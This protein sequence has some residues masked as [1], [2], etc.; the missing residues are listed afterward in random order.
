MKDYRDTVNLPVTDFSM[1]AELAQREPQRIKWWKENKIYEKNLQKRKNSGKVFILHDGPPYSNG[2]I[3]L[4]TALNK[5]LK[6]ILVKYKS[7]KGF[8]APYIPGWDNH[9]MPIELEVIK[10]H[11]DYK[12]LLHDASKIK[13]SDVKKNLRNECREFAKKWVS[14]QREEFERLG[15]LGEWDATYLTM[16]PDYEAKELRV[17]A[18]LV[19]RGYIYRGYLPVHWCPRCRTTLAM[20]EIEYKDK[21][22]PSLWF[23]FEPVDSEFYALVWTTTPWTIISN[24][25][26]AVHPD[27][28]YV[29][30][31][32]GENKYLLAKDRLEANRDILGD[33]YKIEK[34][35]KGKE[36]EGLRFKHPFFDRISVMINGTFVTTEDGTGIVHIAP[37]HGKEDFEVG[38]EYQLP[39]LSPVDEN[40]RFTNEVPLFEGLDTTEASQKVIEVLKS[41]GKFV[42]LSKIIH[43]YPH[44]WRCKGPL[45]FRATHQ[46]FL[47]VDHNGLRGKAL[48]EIS[49]VRWHPE[50]GESRIYASVKERPDWVI[51]RQRTW[52]VFIPSARCKQC[53]ESILLPEVI[54]S[55]AY[56]V[57]RGEQDAW[58]ER[59]IE[60]FLPAG[61]KCPHC[62]GSEFEKE[63][64][65]LDVW[66]DSGISYIVVSEKHGLPWPCDVYLEGSDQHR[67]WFNASLMLGTAYKGSAPYKAVITHGWVVDEEGKA[68]HK[69]LGNV[70]LPEEVISKYGADILRL[71][72]ASSDYTD[73]IRLGSEIL[74]RLV[75]SYR[76]IR[77]TIRFMLGN[78]YDW[79]ETKRVDYRE[80]FPLE[81]Y[82]LGRW[83]EVKATVEDAY[84]NYYFYKVYHTLFNFMVVDLSAFYLD[85][86]KDRLYTWGRESLGRRS[87]Q[88]AIYDILRELLVILHPIIPFTTEEAWQY[89][90]GEKEE[91]VFLAEWPARSELWDNEV[92]RRDFEYLM[93]IREKVL[94]LIERARKD[95]KM[96]SDRLEA[97]V[98]IL[99]AEDNFK[100]VLETYRPFLEELFIVSQVSF[101]NEDS[102]GVYEEFDGFS[103]KIVH[104][105]GN[106][107]ERC[108][109]WH[110]DVG[111]DQEHP[112]LCPKCLNVVKGASK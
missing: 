9:G 75:D 34:V 70:I 24:V 55:L 83:N 43:S 109:I 69:S 62:G 94:L 33:N 32:T 107:C 85:V 80:M 63:D 1:K 35:L 88:T 110:E 64:N 44:C 99:Y 65:I 30:V 8:F 96:L 108:W 15:V 50:E 12:E 49:S 66:F 36:L 6:D 101:E 52:G 46:W 98:L 54:E 42:K 26:L 22:S 61:F 111:K 72:V 13:S 7:L 81:K 20:A 25:A 41:N 47:R 105:R 60:D 39:V 106:K 14:I 84:E 104:A 27:L 40:G 31:N 79:D 100:R 51:S 77:N 18:E 59:E 3:H 38:R 23:K 2:H 19:R 37:G 68:M 53:G 21:E 71:W 67:G 112:G 91:S 89:L 45:I 86:L 11:P 58:L 57:E 76:K 87:A 56:F 4:G 103:L 28:E 16:S 17:L 102:D 74:T 93:K 78:L 48:E 90:P 95:Y 82:I 92:I 73:D 97:R 5:V 10:K 29:V